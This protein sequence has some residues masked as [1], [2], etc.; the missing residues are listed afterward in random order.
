MTSSTPTAL[1]ITLRLLISTFSSLALSYASILFFLMFSG[2][3]IQ[4]NDLESPQIRQ[5]E[6]DISTD[7]Q[8][9][10]LIRQQFI[11]LEIIFFLVLKKQ[12]CPKVSQ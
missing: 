9:A 3:K 4:G 12:I 11:H 8:K 2:K 6:L 1:M 7:A 5:I 10:L